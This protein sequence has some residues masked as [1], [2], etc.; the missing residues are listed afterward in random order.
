MQASRRPLVD[1]T[2]LAHSDADP[3]RSGLGDGQPGLVGSEILKIAAEIRALKAKGAEICNLTV[4]DFDPASVPD[5]GELLR[6][7]RGALAAGETNYPPAVGVLELREAVQRFY[8]RELGLRTR[9]S[10]SSSPAARA[11]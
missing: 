10:R 6:R 7:H 9:S 3:A 8:E 2:D 1:L 4:G 5:P 11:P